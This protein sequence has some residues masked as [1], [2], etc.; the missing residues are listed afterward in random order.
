MKWTRPKPGT[1]K[2]KR[3]FL[4]LPLMIDHETSWLELVTIEYKYH[5]YYAHR[6][7]YWTTEGFVDDQPLEQKGEDGN[8]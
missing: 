2:R 3:K 5:R 7:G 4:L 1:I 6:G 8:G